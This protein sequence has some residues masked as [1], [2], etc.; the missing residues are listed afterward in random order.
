M[1]KLDPTYETDNPYEQYNTYDR[2]NRS[3]DKNNELR[4]SNSHN[5][6][7]TMRKTA[8]FENSPGKNKQNPKL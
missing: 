7:T 6:G 1:K 2:G 3:I 5:G 4:I 8:T